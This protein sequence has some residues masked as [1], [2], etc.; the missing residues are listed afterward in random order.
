MFTKWY[1]NQNKII[2]HKK[3]RYRNWIFTYLKTDSRSA[4]LRFPEKKQQQQQLLNTPNLLY[5]P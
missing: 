4:D 2:C 1:Y 3:R 5:K